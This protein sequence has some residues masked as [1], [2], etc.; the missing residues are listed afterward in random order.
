MKAGGGAAGTGSSA[1]GSKA[2]VGGSGAAAAGGAVSGDIKNLQAEISDMKLNM[3]TLEKERDFYFGKLR[4]IEMLL[5]ANQSQNNPL[6]ENILKIL[7]ASEEE[8]VQIDE[9]GTLVITNSNG[10]IT[11]S[12]ADVGGNGAGNDLVND[13][14]GGLPD[15]GGEDDLLNDDDEEAKLN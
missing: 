11:T 13:N 15:M 10:E 14:D 8:K 1:A 4:D 9:D 3:D 12:G 6:T 7:Y 2:K 5:Q